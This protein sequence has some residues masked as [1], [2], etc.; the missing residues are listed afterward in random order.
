MR[1]AVIAALY[2]D[3]QAHLLNAQTT[4]R[5]AASGFSG[6]D[7]SFPFVDDLAQDHA[8]GQ[9]LNVKAVGTS[10]ASVNQVSTFLHNQAV[11]LGAITPS[12]CRVVVVLPD[13]NIDVNQSSAWAL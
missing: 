8:G 1:Y 4:I 12:T 9:F 11:G 13:G 7:T 2:F 3:T 5:N 10:A 6:L